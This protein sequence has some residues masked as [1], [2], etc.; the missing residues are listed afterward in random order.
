MCWTAPE[1]KRQAEARESADEDPVRRDARGGCR[2]AE[3]RSS[4]LGASKHGLAKSGRAL[5]RDW[6]RMVAFYHY[7]QEHWTHL[8]TATRWSRR[9][10]P[11][12]CGPAAAKRFK[13]VENATAMI[14]KLLLIAEKTFRNLNAP[15]LLA[16]VARATSMSTESTQLSRGDEEGRRLILFTHFL[17]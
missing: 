2:R 3:A 7:P 17:T 13:K 9:S 1:V 11:C 6:E 14:W 16:E 12:D 5:D 4:T 10:P 8:R 15:E